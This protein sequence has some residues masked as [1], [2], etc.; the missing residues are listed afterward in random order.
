M[1]LIDYIKEKYNGSQADFAR[2]NKVQRAQVTQWIGR[3]FVVIDNT[4]YSSR[5]ELK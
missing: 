4:L 1:K 2:A 5:R 3:G